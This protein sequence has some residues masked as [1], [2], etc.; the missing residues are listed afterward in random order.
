MKKMITLLSVLILSLSC[1]FSHGQKMENRNNAIPANPSNPFRYGNDILIHDDMSQDQRSA[2]LSIA[3]NGW[4][5]ATFNKIQGGEGGSE[6][7]KSTDGNTWTNI[8]EFHQAD[9]LNVAVDIVVCGST[10]P[11][12]VVFQAGIVYFPVANY[13]SMYVDKYNGATGAF[14]GEVYNETSYDRMYDIRITSDYKYPSFGASP[15]SVGVLF[16]KYGTA[17]DELIFLSS[18]DGGNTFTNRKT[19]TT[20]AR[21]L[22]KVSL[23]A[24]RSPS[25]SGGRYFASWEERLSGAR[26]GAIYVS[27]TD[28]Y[29]DSDWAVKTRLDDIAGSSLD[30]CK[31][32]VVSCQ[33]G[34]ADNISGEFTSIVIFDRDYYGTGFDYDVIGMFTRES[35]APTPVWSRLD[36]ANDNAINQ[37]ES[38]I[39]YD[40]GYNNFLVTYCDST[41]QK[42][43]YVVNGMDLT[44]P[45][46]WGVISPGY[47]EYPN[48]V[49]PF[50]KVDINPIYLQ[51][52]HVWISDDAIGQGMAVWDAEYITGIPGGKE[53]GISASIYPNPGKEKVNL[54]L[55]LEKPA[56][57]SITLFNV[58]GQK[59][60]EI[61]KES[62]D[63]GNHDLSFS[64]GDLAG[65]CYTWEIKGAS[66][67]ITG[68]LVVAR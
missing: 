53:I 15:Y 44:D 33:A 17:A 64:V 23:S 19:V 60:K 28:P 21:F 14:L 11:D 1:G 57:I 47:N 38:D 29:F 32:P 4:A 18:G 37:F 36:I 49:H 3:Y 46:V 34:S 67:K 10:E 13:Y 8:A 40:P 54:Q 42:L 16:S 65:G 24:G 25:A 58:F 31:N 26:T 30:M 50:P 41:N 35:A 52:G 51:V 45:D 12:L 62:F 39:N 6:I 55:E 59:V 48:L 7:W 2:N 5:F 43:V 27:H 61:A 66:G 63:A 20:T 56:D 9:Y 22:D 68:K